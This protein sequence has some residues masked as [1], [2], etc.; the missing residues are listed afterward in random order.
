MHMIERKEASAL[1]GANWALEYT[2]PEA[3]FE[4]IRTLATN[5]CYEM[6]LEFDNRAQRDEARA[7]LSE[8]G[9]DFE[10][11]NG[12]DMMLEISWG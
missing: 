1:Y 12:N 4:R 3:L 5:G 7:V 11:Y 9:F 10:K 8:A 2:T 6:V